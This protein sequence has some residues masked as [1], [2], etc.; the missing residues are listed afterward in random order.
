MLAGTPPRLDLSKLALDPGM[1]DDLGVLTSL[2]GDEEPY[3]NGEEPPKASD[4]NFNGL[5]T[6]G[7]G[8]LGRGASDDGITEDVDP[9]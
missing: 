9:A 2:G 4:P 7:I 8:E 5:D 1:P 6:T 3:C